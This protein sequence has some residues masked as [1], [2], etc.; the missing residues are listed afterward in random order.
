MK[1]IIAL[2]IAIV[3][4]I[5]IAAC[6]SPA[7]NQADGGTAPKG[8]E[9][10][11]TPKPSPSPSPT[12]TPS[13]TPSLAPATPAPTDTPKDDA[14]APADGDK[15]APE[16]SPKPAEGKAP[17]DETKPAP[18]APK[19]DAQQPA[20]ETKAP[21]DTSGEAP[22]ATP[23]PAAPAPAA[24]QKEEISAAGKKLVMIGRE[25]APEDDFVA[26]RLS[27]LGFK[28]TRVVDKEFTLDETKGMD[29]IY[30]SQTTNSKILK[31]GI[32]KEVA[33]PTVYV[34]NHGMF[35]L[36]LSSI[37]ENANVLNVK[38]IDIVDNDHKVAG[39]LSGSVDIYKETNSKIGI[40]YGLPGKEAKI[41]ATA[42][43]DKEKAAIYYY[44]KG[45]KA[46]DG[47]EVKA[48]VSFFFLNN[49]LQENATDACWKLLDNLVLWTLQNG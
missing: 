31:E 23:A 13:P 12:P 32:M 7:A 11:S 33:I 49:G 18:E 10:S 34:K 1:R 35:Y 28:V 14:K 41:I 19:T 39:G 45:T 3:M 21:A 5:S 6:G 37:E 22:K 9:A 8:A 20:Q 44:D 27:K 2:L 26:D 46:D 17:A 47:Y 48:R 30:F 24:E 15:S 38:S 16:A 25:R 36:G 40:G 4:T 29:L 43:G 42:P